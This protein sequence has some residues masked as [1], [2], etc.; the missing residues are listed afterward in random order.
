MLYVP[1]SFIRYYRRKLH[2]K[3]YAPLDTMLEKAL[4][5]SST[6]EFLAAALFYP[7]LSAIPGG[8]LGY[9]I[10]E[11]LYRY[12]L[13]QILAERWQVE[14]L[15][16]S[17][18]A[19]LAF[20]V[21]RYLILSYPQ[22]VA[23]VRKG[24]IDANLPHAVNTMLGMAKGGVPLIS[25]FRF[26][27]ENK[28]LF[29][30][31]SAEFERIVVLVELFDYDLPAAMR[32]VAETTP[33]DKLKTFLDNFVNVYEGGGNIVEYLRSK[34]D[35]FLSERETFY[36]IFFETLQIFAEI[37]LALFIVAPMFFLVVLVVFQILG[38]GVLESYRIGIYTL[39]PAGSLIVIWLLNSMMPKEIRGVK[40]VE[41][42]VE[43]IDARIEERKPEFSISKLRKFIVRAR[44]FLLR[45]FTE[46]IYTLTFRAVA[47]Y[48]MLPPIVFIT[49]AYGKMP[50]DFLIFTAL[51]A[52]VLPAIFFIEYKEY[53][54][55]KMERELPEF[56][57]QL[58]SLNE[59]GLNVVE[60]LRH[61]SESELGVLGREVRLVKREVEWGEL[62]TSALRKIEQRVKSGVFSKVISMLVKT[63]EATPNLRDALTIASLY[64]EMEV[65]AKS[66]MRSQMSMYVLIIYLSFG[67]FLY[68]AYVLLTNLLSVFATIDATSIGSF[69]IGL[70]VNVVKQ[71]FLETS[72]LVAVFSGVVAGV[73]GEGKIEAG[74]KHTFVL[75]VIVYV[76]FRFIV[77]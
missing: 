39:I 6:A 77:P 53:L 57:K 73:M 5:R 62:V 68:T 2:E 49:V 66:R 42:S 21:T 11:A 76:F 23:N 72:L 54:I 29:G 20:A 34:S 51:V 1:S 40:T 48:I 4:Y 74:L 15:L 37:Y 16:V 12:R 27:A 46:E 14:L 8:M 55:R 65:E 24:K 63:I 59:A 28:Q 71:T 26:I 9:I 44:N 56:L 13:V 35:Q 32:Y 31:V 17:S 19:L 52:L 18:F 7:L 30:E 61:L 69:A 50:L 38:G 3:K 36:T 22:Y 60:A 58:A 25:I 70:D 10:A 67:V 33:S 43:E 41:E 75:V 64:S 47:F 45:P